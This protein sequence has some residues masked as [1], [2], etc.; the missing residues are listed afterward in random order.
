MIQCM[1]ED[2]MI[3]AKDAEIKNLHDNDVYEWVED[4]G[5]DAI[6]S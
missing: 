1:D 2:K 5:Q 3:N 4:K 6:S